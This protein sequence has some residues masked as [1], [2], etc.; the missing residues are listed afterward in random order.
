MEAQLHFLRGLFQSNLCREEKKEAT[1]AG[2]RMTF[3]IS[4][5]ENIDA[6]AYRLTD[7]TKAICFGDNCFI[8]SVQGL[9]E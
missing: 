1:Q 8:R 5:K 4:L 3:L 2:I 6:I 9:H 7:R